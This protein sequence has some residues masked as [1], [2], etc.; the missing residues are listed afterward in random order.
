[1]PEGAGDLSRGSRPRRRPPGPDPGLQRGRSRRPSSCW[2]TSGK[3]AAPRCSPLGRRVHGTR[4]DPVERVRP[5]RTGG[6][7][8]PRPMPTRSRWSASGRQRTADVTHWI[9]SG[10]AG[11]AVVALSFSSDGRYLL[12]GGDPPV[13]RLWD[14]SA[15]RAIWPRRPHFLGSHG[16]AEHHLRG[17]PSHSQQGVT[18]H[19]DGEVDVW[20][21]SRGA[22]PRWT[23]P[24]CHPLVRHGRQGALLHVRWPV[25]A[26]AGDGKRIWVGGMEPR[27]RGRRDGP[28]PGPSRRADQR[29]CRLAGPADPGQRQ[30]RHHDPLLGPPG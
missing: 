17:D 9:T 22:G 23:C 15:A 8:L 21:W 24:A 6:G 5:R 4:G 11:D 18:G 27:P 13:A 29:P 19:S 20:K 28:D 2:P 10:P 7:S 25:L 26:A 14:L 30:R 3:R 16:H 12:T 1:M